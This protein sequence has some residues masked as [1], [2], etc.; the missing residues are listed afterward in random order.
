MSFGNHKN[1]IFGAPS[2]TRTSTPQGH[3]VLSVVCLPIPIH[4]SKIF[5]EYQVLSCSQARRTP[6]HA[7]LDV[8][9]TL[10]CLPTFGSEVYGFDRPLRL[11]GTGSPKHSH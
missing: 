9:C 10:G 2:R 3:Y 1:I 7:W 4:W 5:A 8:S 11:T 6:R